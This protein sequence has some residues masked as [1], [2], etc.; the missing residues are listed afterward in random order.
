M[1]VSLEK[2]FVAQG[3]LSVS[4]FVPGQ[5]VS[6]I[7]GYLLLKYSS[8]WGFPSLLTHTAKQL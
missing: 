1:N 5:E 2:A 6:G 3:L 4:G 8:V 7:N